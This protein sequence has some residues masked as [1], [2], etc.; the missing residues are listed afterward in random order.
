MAQRFKTNMNKLRADTSSFDTG[1]GGADFLK[2]TDGKHLLR[3]LPTWKEDGLF[4]QKVGF[5]RPPGRDQVSKKVICP[6]YTF[7]KKGTCPICKAKQRVYKQLGK[8][9][10]KDYAF[11]KRAY[12]NV[13]DMKAGDGQVKVFEAPATVMNPIL[14]FMAE[15]DSDQLVDLNEGFNILITRKKDGGFTKYEVMVKPGQFDLE[16]KGFDVDNILESLV[17]LDKFVT[18]PEA[19]DFQEILDMLNDATFGEG[20]GD[21]EG[22]EHADDDPPPKKLKS[23]KVQA[24]AQ[25]DDDQDDPPPKALKKKAAPVVD[26]DDEDEPAPPPK[27]KA[28]PAPVEEDDDAD[29]DDDEPA[30]PPKKAA[31]TPLKKKAAPAPVEDDEDDEPAPPKKKSKPAPV[32]DDDL[33]SLEDFDGAGFDE[34]EEIPF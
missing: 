34:N 10:A 26:E 11:Q 21:D 7:G 29:E 28:A 5:H 16:A 22:E 1:G 24:A 4:Y 23:T 33:D 32:E 27:K 12:L 30:P 13:L 17:H 2:M 3:I 6:D 31:P 20:G 8:D 19:D 25:D 15:E 18:P 14:N 9:A